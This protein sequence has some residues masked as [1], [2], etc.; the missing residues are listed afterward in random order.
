MQF[1][2]TEHSQFAFVSDALDRYCI[3][4]EPEIQYTDDTMTAMNEAIIQCELTSPYAK[5][6]SIDFDIDGIIKDIEDVAS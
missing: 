3:E 1:V 2:Y 4:N 6:L 5:Y